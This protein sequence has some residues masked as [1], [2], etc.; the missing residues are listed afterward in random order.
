MI[1]YACI[2]A[3]NICI[4]ICTFTAQETVK[5]QILL[6]YNLRCPKNKK[7]L[8]IKIN[9]KKKTNPHNE[10]SSKCMKIPSKMKHSKVGFS[11]RLIDGHSTQTSTAKNLFL[12]AFHLQYIGTCNARRLNSRHLM[13]RNC[14]RTLQ[15]L[16]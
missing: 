2:C 1:T 7:N 3:V 13:K 10:T 14:V 6:A 4:T 5:I 8:D 9:E 12:N 16:R 11:R 15:Y